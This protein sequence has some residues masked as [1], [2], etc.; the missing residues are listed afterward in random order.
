ML[1]NDR[2]NVGAHTF[3][4]TATATGAFQEY[5]G[6]ATQL[7][8]SIY[9]FSKQLSSASQYNTIPYCIE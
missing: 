2:A 4:K 7:G 8:H 9:P 6:A 1:H 3:T 5:R